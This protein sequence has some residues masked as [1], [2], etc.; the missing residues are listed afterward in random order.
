VS[1]F[2]LG[3]YRSES[4]VRPV[5]VTE[6]GQ[7]DLQDLARRD[8]RPR[9]AAALQGGLQAVMESWP[10][11]ETE[12]TA[13]ARR[14]QTEP[15]G[16]SPTAEETRFAAPFRP[17]RIFAAASNYVEHANEMGTALA[18][19]A[20]S[21]P[22]IFIKASSSVIG[23]GESIV[24]PP[25]TERVDWEVEL[26]AVIGHGGRNIPVARALE[27]IAGFT[28]FN[29]VSARDLTRR[30]DFPFKFDWFQGKSFDTFGPLGPWIV[31]AAV[32]GDP[33]NLR[34]TL[35]LNDKVM[36]DDTSGAMIFNIAEQISYLSSIL[37]LSPGDVIATG[38]PNGVGLGHGVFL[39]A[40][41]TVSARI[42]KIGALTN[43]VIAAP[44]FDT[45]AV[46]APKAGAKP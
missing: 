16:L 40:G 2:A 39:K 29:D 25:M 12:V 44:P 10:E 6:R 26:A 37:T 43:P 45:A 21:A 8:N 27:H 31:P 30:N 46:L 23:P 3:S 4:G 20:D 33:Q 5:L 34:L 41:D 22:Y 14:A 11:L 38:T 9:L 24:L 36:Q 7:F 13:L 1:W 15:E 17:A 35:T 28:V 18:G 32:I 19:K 42:E